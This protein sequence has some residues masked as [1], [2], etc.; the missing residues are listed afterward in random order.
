MKNVVVRTVSGFSVRN[1]KRSGNKT[2]TSNLELNPLQFLFFR[3][4]IIIIVLSCS[5]STHAFFL[6]KR[7]SFFFK[8][9]AFLRCKFS[10]V[11]KMTRM[12]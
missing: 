1:G 12:D 7:A 10:T 8:M 2:V 11:R 9:R 5:R 4:L 3:S 6:L